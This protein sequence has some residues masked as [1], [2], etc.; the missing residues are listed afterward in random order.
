MAP[1]AAPGLT[2]VSVSLQRA[3]EAG[4]AELLPGIPGQARACGLLLRSC[5]FVD[6]S[7]ASPAH[8]MHQCLGCT[9]HAHGALLV[10]MCIDWANSV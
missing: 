8:G 5:V 7:H 3:R 9:P 2:C 6:A 4:D 1:F 10:C